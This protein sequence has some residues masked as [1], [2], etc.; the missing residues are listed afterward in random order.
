MEERMK[1]KVIVIDDSRT[2]RQCVTTVLVEAGYDVIE[3][4]DGVD[5]LAQIARNQDASMVICDLNM[6]RMSGLDV[7]V[8]LRA[9]KAVVPPFLMLTTEAQPSVVQRAKDN[10]ARGWVIKPF[11]P[12][13][14]LATVRKLAV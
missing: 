11:K 7:L 12:D 13:L 4:E 14:L 8:A 3:A 1:K 5:G 6:P 2:A 9:S 10:G